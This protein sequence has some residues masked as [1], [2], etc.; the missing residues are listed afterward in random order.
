[1]KGGTPNSDRRRQRLGANM[2]LFYPAVFYPWDGGEGYT[3]DVPDLLG[4]VSE[5]DTLE[6]AILMGID[7]ASGWILGEIED[8]KSAP[9]PSPIENIKPDEGEDGFVNMLILDIDEYAKKWGRQPAKKEIEIPAYLITFADEHQINISEVVQNLL[10]AAHHKYYFRDD[11]E[12]QTESDVYQ[13]AHAQEDEGGD[14]N[15][16]T[17]ELIFKQAGIE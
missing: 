17:V 10:S 1:M 7:A 12:A 6:K 9:P 3:V 13:E 16:K 15:P 5:G 14:L 8:G 11:E 4:C 2:K